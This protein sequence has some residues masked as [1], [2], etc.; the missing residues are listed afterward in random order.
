M[1]RGTG[2][3]KVRRAHRNPDGWVRI[4]GV[5]AAWLVYTDVMILP[6]ADASAFAN[7]VECDDPQLAAEVRDV[8]VGGA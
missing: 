3:A 6:L 1:P 2:G 4:E 8:L 5:A 7:Y